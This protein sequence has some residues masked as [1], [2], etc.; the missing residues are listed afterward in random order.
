MP[1]LGLV[2]IHASLRVIT[3]YTATYD[4]YKYVAILDVSTLRVCKDI[5]RIICL[6]KR[7]SPP[8]P[9]ILTVEGAQVAIECL[10]MLSRSSTAFGL[11]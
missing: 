3:I 10:R 1:D 11:N 6:A 5:Y 7:L 8:P 4:R 2:I 9:S